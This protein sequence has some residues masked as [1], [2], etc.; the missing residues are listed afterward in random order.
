MRKISNKQPN[1]SPKRTG[2]RTTK[3]KV[4]KEGNH[5]DQRGNRVIFKNGKKQF[6]LWYSRNESN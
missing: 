4:S 6:L 2:K 3:P 5:K 1:P